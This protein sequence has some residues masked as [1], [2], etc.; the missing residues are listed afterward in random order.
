MC[1]LSQRSRTSLLFQNRVNIGVALLDFGVQIDLGHGIIDVRFFPLA[2]AKEKPKTHPLQHTA[3]RYGG[4]A[5]RCTSAVGSLQP[6]LQKAGT[7]A[8]AIPRR[9]SKLG[10]TDCRL[11]CSCFW[12]QADA[13]PESLAHTAAHWRIN[14]FLLVVYFVVTKGRTVFYL[15]E[16]SFNKINHLA[17]CLT[18]TTDPRERRRRKQEQTPRQAHE[19]PT[20]SRRHVCF[21]EID[22][23]ATHV[24]RQS[25]FGVSIFVFGQMV[26]DALLALKERGGSSL[27]ALKK[28]IT[29]THPELA[30]APHRLRSALK[31]GLDSGTLVK[32]RTLA[33]RGGRSSQCLD[34]VLGL[35]SVVVASLRSQQ[36][37][38]VLSWFCL[39]CYFFLMRIFAS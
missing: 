6:A 14:S 5:G 18:Q 23:V 32:V 8:D 39:F 28:Y 27:P 24:R 34:A 13:V 29:M 25:F 38:C 7:I 10:F 16:K 11:A 3:R 33:C 26:V 37:L 9:F 35:L 1:A 21:G 4:A 17:F 20:Q 22:T 31:A 19:P 12:Q 30:F 15:E 36:K 2:A